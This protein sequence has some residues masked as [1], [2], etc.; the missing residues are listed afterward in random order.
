MLNLTQTKVWTATTDTL[1]NSTGMTIWK[2]TR[3]TVE[4][5]SWT[6]ILTTI[7]IPTYL[8]TRTSSADTVDV[9]IKMLIDSIRNTENTYKVW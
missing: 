8:Q 3:N 4:F 6:N 1:K 5:I 2:H 9:S 7:W